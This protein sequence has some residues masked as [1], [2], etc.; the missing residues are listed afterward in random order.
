MPVPIHCSCGKQFRVPDGY[1]GKRVR[2]PACGQPAAV[3]AAAASAGSIRPAARAATA[4]P[5]AEPQKIS[6]RCDCGQAMQARPE[7]A[8]LKTRCPSCQTVVSIPGKKVSAQGI[9]HR[10][11]GPPPVPSRRETPPPRTRPRRVQEDDEDDLDY[12]EDDRPRRRR[13]A[14]KRGSALLWILVGAASLLLLLGGGGLAAWYFWPRTAKDLALVPGDAPL[15]AHIRVADFLSTDLGKQ[16][17]GNLKQAGPGNPLNNMLAKVGLEI[18][19]IERLTIVATDLQ[20]DQAYVIAATNKAMDRAKILSLLQDVKDATYEGKKYQVGIGNGEVIG[21]HWVND[22][23]LMMGNEEALK[24]GL[25]LLGGKNPSGPQDAAIK[26]AGEKHHLV[27]GVIPPAGAVRQPPPGAPP[28]FMAGMQ[29]AADVKNATLIVDVDSV[30]KLEA[31]V[32]MADEAKAQAAKKQIDGLTGLSG[33]FLPMLKGQMTPALGA[34]AADQVYK[35]IKDTV[36]SIKAEQSGPTLTVRASCNIKGILDSAGPALPRLVMGGMNAPGA[37]MPPG[38]MPPNPGGGFPNPG[39]GVGRPGGGF[40]NPG[41]GVP[42]PPGGRRGF[43]PPGGRA[44]GG[45]V[46][47][48]SPPP[49]GRFPPNPGGM[50]NPGGGAPNP[51]GE[52]PNP[53]GVFNPAGGAG[54]GLGGLFNAPRRVAHT[55][56]LKQL[57]LAMHIYHDTYRRF[58]PAVI[59]DRTGRPLYSWRVALLPFL[60]QEALY[61][62]FKLDEPWDSPNNIR[63]LN[64]MPKVF[65]TPN[66]AGSKTCY[67]VFVGPGTP[68]TGDGRQG[69]SLAQFPDG[70]SNTLLIAEA[71]NPVEWTKPDDIRMGPAIDPRTLLGK[72]VDA[73]GFYAALAD[74]ST[75]KVP[76]T[77]SVE[78]LRNAINPADGNVLGADWPRR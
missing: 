41:A 54:G 60:E 77:I 27:V 76:L 74:G 37:G 65:A 56:N 4:A 8:G 51:G 75:L 9:A 30:V 68:W 23:F 15:F 55:N 70:T 52:N 17:P 42:N 36:D 7:H 14:K 72:Q 48:R 43:L 66:S 13:G 32:Q 22:K 71:A 47:P 24:R 25:G 78:T 73:D 40:P 1:A 18:T 34:Q 29:A 5:V 10:P 44:G 50:P 11:S 28:A 53:P 2:C 20:H 12:E 61:K 62:Q 33:M 45:G 59:C 38:Q 64:Q 26:R 46:G 57:A 6:F 67:Q 19:D 31:V 69:P 35:H 16:L 39:A 21:L 49:G 3:P 58:P 63:L